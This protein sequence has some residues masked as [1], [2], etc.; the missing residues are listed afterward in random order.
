VTAVTVETFPL[1]VSSWED[2]GE[3]D[4][5]GEGDGSGDAAGVPVGSAASG[6]DEHAAIVATSSATSARVLT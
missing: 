5:S 1:A 2:F 6:P 4:G 3:F